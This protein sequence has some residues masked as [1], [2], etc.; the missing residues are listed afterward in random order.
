LVSVALRGLERTRIAALWLKMDTM[1]GVMGGLCLATAE[2]TGG[3]P[4]ILKF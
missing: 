2:R 4:P 1:T 3:L